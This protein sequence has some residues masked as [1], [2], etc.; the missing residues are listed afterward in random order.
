MCEETVNG[1]AVYAALAA[2]AAEDLAML[3][4]LITQGILEGKVGSGWGTPPDPRLAVPESW[5][6]DETLHSNFQKLLLSAC[7]TGKI[8][9][10]EYLLHTGVDLDYVY[11]SGCEEYMSYGYSETALQLAATAGHTD[12]VR[13]LIEAGADVN[14]GEEPALLRAVACYQPGRWDVPNAGYLNICE[15]L[16][17]A[18]ANVNK[19]SPLLLSVTKPETCL[20]ELLIRNGANLDVFDSQGRSLL[21]RAMQERSYDNAM[22]LLERGVDVRHKTITDESALS[23]AME[24]NNMD[25]VL[26][27]LSLWG[28]DQHDR[29]IHILAKRRQPVF[30]MLL[31]AAGTSVNARDPYTGSS[32]L[33]TVARSR[34]IC[35][36]RT[37]LRLGADAN[38]QSKLGST[39]LWVA[40][41]VGDLN[42]VKA[43]LRWNSNMDIPSLEHYI[44]HPLTPVQI[45]LQLQ[46]WDIA[47]MLLTAGCV[48]HEHWCE[49]QGRTLPGA[50]ARLRVKTALMEWCRTPRSLFHLAAIGIR[51]CLGSKL[52]WKVKKLSLPSALK[53]SVI[54]IGD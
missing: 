9:V 41:Q 44:M 21:Q 19:G 17:Q 47:R 30:V 34:N 27:I 5:L 45:A 48:F 1:L 46:H 8:S 49:L 18:G 32:L 4:E 7:Q 15:A 24:H 53:Y 50:A 23:C 51:S 16:V 35:L 13:I 38:L 42:L 37:L 10:V 54:C 40:V 31:L 11:D 52:P 20:T 25:L 28:K 2:V 3:E 14:C 33:L 12:C 26:R 36:F 22:L 6:V 43:L 29:L 39:P